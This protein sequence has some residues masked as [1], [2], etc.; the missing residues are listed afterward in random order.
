MVDSDS[1]TT[2]MTAPGAD[3][4]GDVFEVTVDVTDSTGRT[5]TR[6]ATVTESEPDPPDEPNPPDDTTT[7]TVAQSGVW[8]DPSTWEVGRPDDGDVAVVPEGTTLTLDTET[9]QLLRLEVHG[10]FRVDPSQS[11]HLRSETIMTHEGSS[12]EAGTAANPANDARFTFPK[13]T[14]LGSARTK[15]GI[16][17]MGDFIAHGQPKTPFVTLSQPPE[18]GDTSLSLAETPSNWR[19]GDELI[20]PGLSPDEDQDESRAITSVG[21][22]SVSLDA[23]LDFDHVPPRGDLDTYALNMDRSVTFESGTVS[24]IDDRAH[25]MGMTVGSTFKYCEFVEMGRTDKSRPITNGVR[26]TLS[27]DHAPNPAARYPIHWHRTGTST[28][29][30]HVVQGVVIDGSP[31][32]GVTNHH[33]YV[34]CSDSITYNCLGAGFVSEGGNEKGFFRNCFALR[35]EGSGE[36]I[37]ARAHGAHGGDDGQRVDDFG[38]AGHG[39]WN[40]SPRVEIT[41]CVAAGHRHKAFAWWLRPLLDEIEVTEA[42][43]DH[44]EDSRVTFCP[45]L[46]IERLDM[47]RHGP[48]WE[49][50]QEGR[51]GDRDSLSAQTGKI[52]S[53][54]AALKG[55]SGCTGFASGG[56]VE[57]SRQNFKWKHERFSDFSV[58]DDMTIYNVGTFV[59]KNGEEHSPNLPIHQASGHQGRGGNVG[60]DFRYTSNVA[61]K[62]SRVIGT[63]RDHSI[64]LP[65][66]DYRWS[67]LVENCDIEDWDWG[68][69]M[70]EHRLDWVRNSTFNGNNVDIN[71]DFDHIGPGI[72][73]NCD[74]NG[75]RYGF[76]PNAK[77]PEVFFSNPNRGLTI[78]GRVVHTNESAPDHVPF[79]DSNSLSRVN[80]IERY[81]DTVNNES[82]LV[83]LTNE[84]M[85]NQFGI[86][87]G[88]Y[89]MPADA[90]SDPRLIEST[91]DP[92]TIDPPATVVLDAN[93]DAGGTGGFVSRSV[94]DVAGGTCLESTGGSPASYSFECA[95]G[96]YKVLLRA[97]PAAWNGSNISF[98]VDGGAWQTAE[99]LKTPVGFQWFTASP[100]NGAPYTFDLGSGQHTLEVEADSGVQIDE[101]AVGTDESAVGGYGMSQL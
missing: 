76:L 2:E 77:A 71:W 74:F 13:L 22:G 75:A 95:S 94:P 73:D 72:V 78:D 42:E 89:P 27:G 91:M 96:T 34:E 68:F 83:G 85:W 1:D 4:S 33:A 61:L 39:F 79:P 8:S 81:I 38:H 54:F 53:T 60:I 58:L 6:S 40:Q 55:V 12:F 14:D 26:G 101:I 63:G 64:G 29:V 30:P 52:C 31:G 5:A 11:V 23:P 93:T 100:N 92:E 65:F 70:G 84:Q 69:A 88:G 15:R 87:I 49:A 41:D 25:I 45:N 90:V 18:S 19:S 59:D 21:G 43:C 9:K 57:Y 48:L 32:W 35:S 66:H 80:N 36:V 20:I 46:P 51:F 10:S 28:D 99:K 62:N 97:R 37:D 7:H 17:F 67:Y 98:R 50:I 82:D 44:V 24:P 86:A 56:G 47:E 16:M 3:A